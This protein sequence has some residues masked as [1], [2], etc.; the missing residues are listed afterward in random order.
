[1]ARMGVVSP[2]A[3]FLATRGE[4]ELATTRAVLWSLIA[5]KM[6]AGWGVQWHLTIG[7]DSFCIPPHV[8]TYAGVG[9]SVLLSFGLLAW[10]TFTAPRI[11]PS[12]L[13]SVLGVVGTRGTHIA[14]GGIALTVLAA[15]F[16]DL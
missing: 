14:A 8:L 4:V 7:R 10:T 1:M 5:S 16:D 2:P 11:L 6:V 9:L 13:V 3:A 12:H 15:P